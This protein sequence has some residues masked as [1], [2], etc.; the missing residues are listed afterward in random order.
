MPA[1]KRRYNTRAQAE[2]GLDKDIFRLDS[3]TQDIR[4]LIGRYGY[5]KDKLVLDGDLNKKEAAEL[6]I[7]VAKIKLYSKK[8]KQIHE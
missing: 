5:L 6:R 8:L 1:S 3:F 2:T 4:Y 7:L